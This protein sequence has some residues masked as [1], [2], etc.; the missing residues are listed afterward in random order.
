MQA[1]RPA[2]ER[3]RVAIRSTAPKF[4]PFERSE[5]GKKHLRATAF[6]N[7]EDNVLPEGEI[8][9]DDDDCL[10]EHEC[11]LPLTGK[12]KKRPSDIIYIDEVLESAH[13]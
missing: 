4:R 9:D 13:R 1:I 11:F 3:F 7:I 2:Q 10:E 8:S 6:L 12:R 5:A